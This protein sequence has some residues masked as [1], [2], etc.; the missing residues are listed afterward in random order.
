MDK[1]GKWVIAQTHENDIR[2]LCRGLGISPLAARV[3][4][5]RG[6]DT[7]EKAQSFLSTDVSGIASPDL[8]ADMDRAV[9]LI[10]DALARGDR[11]AVYGDYDV[12]GITATSIMVSYLRGRGGDCRYY[13]PDRINEGY[14]LNLCA[15]D[16]LYNDGCRL[17]ITVDSGITAIEEIDHA[18]ELGMKVVI[19]DHHECGERLPSAHAVVNPRRADSLHPFRELAGVGVAFK[20]IC[21][22]EKGRSISSLLDEYADIVAL[23]TIADVMPMVGE[24][25]IIVSRGLRQLKNTENVGLRALVQKLGL[26]SKPITANSVSFVLAPRINAAG[27]L[28][29]AECTAKLMLTEDWDEACRLADHLCD[30][31]RRRQEEENAIYC[32][33]VDEID[34]D[35]SL[36]AGKIMV[37]WGEDWH[38]GVIGIVSSRLTEKYGK[39]CVLISADGE[40]GKGSGRSIKGFNLYGALCSAADLLERYGGHELAVGLTVR[41]ENLPELRKR[42]EE[43]AERCC[44]EEEIESSLEIDCAIEPEELSVEAVKGLSVLEPFGMGNQMPLFMMEDAV[45]LE[46]TPISHERHVKLLLEKDGQRVCGFVFGMGSRCCPFVVG[47]KVDLAFS[48]EIN[49]F[50]GRESVQLVIKDI[51]WSSCSVQCDLALKEFYN[52]AASGGEIDREHALCLC[53]CRDDLVAVFRH[54]KTNQENGMLCGT[55]RTLY[56]KI[57]YESKCCMNLGRFLVCMDILKE[58]DI[59]DYERAGENIIIKDLNYKGK[60]D[61]NGSRIIKKFMDAIKG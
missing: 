10:E 18:T 40:K 61:I 11:I 48:A 7:P 4:S 58:F 36:A 2:V 16:M 1:R 43:Y 6:I 3:L 51:R 14:G 46:I 23:G 26:D 31:N 42:L 38:T 35:P 21:A 52:I 45:I 44:L 41:R 28:G 20:L 30:L 9:E 17:L 39:P 53:P 25:R 24:N 29:E 57:K 33:I 22:M 27:R 15:V 32:R 34:R 55:P 12:D 5:A 47:D 54:I 19:T 59:F 37:L 56:R 60:V 50:R 13:I 49:Y 8:L